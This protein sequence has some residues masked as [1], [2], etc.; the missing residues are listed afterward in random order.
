MAQR[1]LFE[2][3]SEIGVF[4]KLTNSYCLVAESSAY[5]HKFFWKCFEN[6]LSSHIPVIPTTIASCRTI[7]RMTVGNSKG[8]LL[9]NTTTD[10][11]LLHIRN[12]LPDSVIVTRVE[13]R[14]SALGNVITCNDYVGLVHPDL[15]RET[16]E[17]I[18]DT[19][20]IE[21]FRG[22]IAS[23]ALVGSY[24]AI[25]NRGALVHP[26]CSLEDQN[27]LASLLQ[28]PLM[29]GTINRGSSVI[30][31]GLVVND[32]AAFCGSDTTA[33]EIMVVENIFQI[34]DL[35][36]QANEFASSNQFR[37]MMVEVNM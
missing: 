19:L 15:D 13:E 37:Q 32:W 28:V 12:S 6:E 10:Q 3:S 21:V 1:T 29:A 11:E 25:T 20:G 23:N 30:G 36:Y 24:C 27:E 9:P 31:A 33:T 8:L 18:G 16:E 7:G 34:K 22:T 17:I 5:D 2:N 26:S 35:S 4:A 14:L